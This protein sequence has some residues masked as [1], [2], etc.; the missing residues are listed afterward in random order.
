[1]IPV[2]PVTPSGPASPG[3]PGGPISPGRPSCPGFPVSPTQLHFDLHPTQSSLWPLAWPVRA[4]SPTM[5]MKACLSKTARN[6]IF[7]VCVTVL[8]TEAA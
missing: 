3:K 1:M 4:T 8:F 6:F 7:K 5:Q 2:D